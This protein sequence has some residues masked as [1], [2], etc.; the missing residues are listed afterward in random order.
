MTDRPGRTG[1]DATRAVDPG[2]DPD[3]IVDVTDL[4]HAYGDLTVLDDVSFDLEPGTVACVIG[5]NGSGKST[6]LRLVGGL[7]A[8]TSGRVDVHVTGDRPI[9]Y[10]A[11]TPSFRPQFTV[12]ETVAFY[13]SLVE[14]ETDVD[15]T[16]DRVGL[17]PVADRRVDALSG[18]MTHLL[19]LALTTVGDP[20]LLLLD[21]PA[22][23]LDPMMT[24]YITGVIEEIAGTGDAVM[25]AT[26]TLSAAER[27]AD[28]VLV[29][30][31]GELAAADAPAAIVEETG[32][33]SLEA[34][35]AT[36]ADAGEIPTVTS[37]R[38][39]GT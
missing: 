3:P 1:T 38:R 39:G 2:S 19:G 4:G 16:L 25:L 6:L 24:T 30:D 13:G 14:G 12:A 10:L 7:L 23:G 37:G 22:S 20:P 9:G 28:V 17:T 8:P 32:T 21:E 26:H 34:A 11:Q 33:D 5:A 29:L 35:L 18:G 27:I 31:G 36:I 15:A